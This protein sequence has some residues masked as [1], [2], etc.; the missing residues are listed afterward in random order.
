M[1][2]SA[3]NQN[4][5]T[6]SLTAP[7]L[8]AQAAVIRAALENARIKPEQIGY[9]EVH[10]NGSP[11]G[12]PVELDALRDA[13]GKPRADG[14][15]CVLGSVKTFIGHSE[16]ASSMASLIK[17][18]LVLNQETI[19]RNL[20]FE[21]L[22]PNASL[23][24]TPFVLPLVEHTWKRIPAR[25]FAG[26]SATGLSGTNVHAIL[27]E[28]PTVVRDQDKPERPTHVFVLSGKTGTALRDRAKQMLRYLGTHADV[29]LGDQCHTLA[30][31]R[32]H[33]EHRYAAVVESVADAIGQLTDFVE[34]AASAYCVGRVEN[35]SARRRAAFMFT[36]TAAQ[37]IGVLGAIHATPPVFLEALRRGDD[38]VQALIGRRVSSLLETDIRAT[39]PDDAVD[40]EL[41]LF[42]LQA[43]L[44][45][46]WRSWG[47]EP[48]A[49]VGEGTGE[50]VAAWAA[51]ALEFAEALELATV[52]ARFF[53]TNGRDVE[54]LGRLLARL[55]LGTPK[56][57]FIASLGGGHSIASLAT[58]AYWQAQRTA[59]FD[60][61]VFIAQFSTR[62]HGACIEIGPRSTMISKSLGAS[63]VLPVLPSLRLRVPLH[64]SLL[65]TLAS[66]YVAGF[67]IRWD[68]FNAPHPYR[69]ISLPT[70]PFQRE[71]YWFA[72]AP[73]SSTEAV[74]SDGHPL[75]G[76]LLE[77]RA[78]RPD[79]RV[80][81]T[82][83]GNAH[84]QTIGVQ[85]LLG[86][87]VVSSG[88]L[89]Q[90]A[91][92]AAHE[93]FLER[94]WEL[95]L[96][97][98]DPP[99]LQDDVATTMQVIVTPEGES[100]ASIGIF[101]RAR[102][103][104]PW[105]PVAR[106]TIQPEQSLDD[107]EA[108]PP[109]MRPGRRQPV[110][111]AL[112]ERRLETF[113]LDTDAFRIEQ[114][115]RR[116]GETVASVIVARGH[117][118][119]SFARAAV[120]IA[121]ITHP[122]LHGRW[123]LIESV[124]GV[125][126][127][128]MPNDVRSWLRLTWHDNNGSVAHISVELINDEGLVAA[129][130]RNITLRAQDPAVV[131]RA[132]GKDP[133]DGAFVDMVWKESPLTPPTTATKRKWV[134]LT[135]TGGVGISLAVK[136]QLAGDTVITLPATV[137]EQRPEM[138][139]MVLEV[140]GPFYGVVHIGALDGPVDASRSHE[141]MEEGLRKSVGI[142]Q[143]IVG[144]LARQ[145]YVPRLWL[146]TRGA[147]PAG[148]TLQSVAQAG[149]WG[150]GRVLSIERPDM[151]GGMIDMGS[152]THVADATD[153]MQALVGMGGE[154]HVA[155]RRGKFYVARL[156]RLALSTQQVA[157]VRLDRSYL[158]TGARTVMGM[159]LAHWLAD[160]GARSIVLVHRETEQS[161]PP[162]RTWD[163]HYNYDQL[164]SSLR[165]RGVNVVESDLDV[166]KSNALREL[167]AQCQ[168][169]VA[170]IFHTEG[171]LGESL[172]RLTGTDAAAALQN[173]LLSK[174]R[175][176]WALHSISADQQ[177]DFFV[178]FTAVP[179]WLG[180]EGLGVDAT[181][182]E[183]ADAVIRNRRRDGLAGT[184]IRLVFA[185]DTRMGTNAIDLD[186]LSAGFQGLSADMSLQAME[187]AVVTGHAAVAVTWAD[188]DLFE[189]TQRARG[190]RALFAG[191]TEGRRVRTGA[192]ALQRRVA[193]AELGQ[194]RRTVETIV[195]N[196]VTRVLGAGAIDV[197]SNQQEL[198]SF[199][200]DS[201][202]AL[203]V[204]TS[205]GAIFGV[206]LPAATLLQHP[207]IEALSIR[208]IQ[209]VRRTA[210]LDP[211]NAPMSRAG[212]SIELNR[213]TSK[214]PFFFAPPLTGS[215]LIFQT[216][217][218]H[219]SK[220]RPFFSFSAPGVDT[221][222]PP[223]DRVEVLAARFLEAIREIQPHGPYR[224][225]GYSFGSLV[226]YEMAQMLMRIGEYVDALI[227]GDL[228][229]PRIHRDDP[230]PF[231]QFARMVGLPVEELALH[232]LNSEEQAA[233]IAIATGDLL[234]L[235]SEVAESARQIR[236]Y[237]AHLNAIHEYT[238]VPYAGPVTLIRTQ[239]TVNNL[240][241]AGYYANDPTLGWSR[242]CQQSVRVYDIGGN[243][244]SALS[245][246]TAMELAHTLD[247][248]L[249]STDPK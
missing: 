49:V 244:L 168:L 193:A 165:T 38:A 105:K 48:A 169:P 107:E 74:Q 137:L 192:A 154:D 33:F 217:V 182:V 22:N 160:R 119:S 233:R 89:V 52:R 96:L 145:S 174:V 25:R 161:G 197:I 117:A 58:T 41:A 73:V 31:G 176:L 206:T 212:I 42:I 34:G 1:R 84:H 79:I 205:I 139:E 194:A 190:N 191:V 135:D 109:S 170:G 87:S 180:W 14:S 40:D 224:L 237:R 149:L 189:H 230:S 108:A 116:D 178:N 44:V 57:A 146:V 219:S 81:E 6:A 60:A 221:D 156:T 11:F 124:E 128:A 15:P 136:L 131:L 210:T 249:E 50:C 126:T 30:A 4:G 226:A 20:H 100:K 231:I 93:A 142:A 63:D 152:H 26:V 232:G 5:R 115:W 175:A 106:G 54:E 151:W 88:G 155:L 181:M 247:R 188:W 101:V 80:W 23:D 125:T 7:N 32:T 37:S 238:P 67:E 113:G 167:I 64:R 204:L 140:S 201:I 225:G 183:F 59:A 102:A 94:T 91:C 242:L 203:Q 143:F 85:Y 222:L 144:C 177:C 111:Q 95:Q 215:G 112:W 28:P 127:K 72:G 98:S 148:D 186:A 218:E 162:I 150:F 202:M 223:C 123:W 2:G 77:A 21:S 185:N 208:I 130:A 184:S 61:S 35:V 83:F 99:T 164:V 104:A 55:S 62:G 134:V 241:Q 246:P 214:A 172:H 133:F 234:G 196:E 18:V 173:S 132:A 76:R 216:L 65:G 86:T 200:M 120:A 70:Y 39:L 235:P 118:S 187:K 141:S 19:P 78:D 199:G 209:A 138:L 12:D 195:R 10:S 245:V 92:A 82:I 248:I 36:G 69:R 240:V 68:N 110:A 9:V 51:G 228:P 157:E 211:S 47:I 43:A 220:V 24:G 239:A 75:L 8:Q 213:G 122:A 17:T 16:A 179:S 46:L 3:M 158:V 207:S 163:P 171:L 129:T 166:S 27:E 147:Q 103:G 66:L 229:P 45:E 13:L 71:R 227:L 97:L 90:V 53:K 153:L 29:S 121:S 159:A 56:R 114:L 243:H 236:I 198:T